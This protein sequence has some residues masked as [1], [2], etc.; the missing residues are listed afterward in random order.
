MCPT[1]SPH[2]HCFVSMIPALMLTCH[3]RLN[4]SGT[5]LSHVAAGITAWLYE[6]PADVEGTTAAATIPIGNGIYNSRLYV[7]DGDLQPVPVGV[8]G[9]LYISGVQVRASLAVECAAGALLPD[10]YFTAARFSI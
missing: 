3:I 5:V 4:P 7:V 1:I 10:G 2:C 9:E 6:P 8:P